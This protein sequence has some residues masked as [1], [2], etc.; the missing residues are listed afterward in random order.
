MAAITPTLRAA[1]TNLGGV[2]KQYYGTSGTDQADTFTTPVCQQGATQKL[3]YV[4]IGY[5]GSATYT[6]TALTVGIDSGISALYD[7]TLTSGTDNTRYTVYLPDPD[8]RLL[9]GD[10]I[11]AALPAGGA[12]REASITVTLLET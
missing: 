9:P 3:L 4:A 5:D 7:L 12:G 6:G 1:P 2:V 10:A 8:I 11:V